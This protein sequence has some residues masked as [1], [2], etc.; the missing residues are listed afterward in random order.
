MCVCGEDEGQNLAARTWRYLSCWLENWQKISWTRLW[1]IISQSADYF[2]STLSIACLCSELFSTAGQSSPR[3]VV[4]YVLCYL[5]RHRHPFVRGRQYV[6]YCCC[7][8]IWWPPSCLQAQN[9]SRSSIAASPESA[10]LLQ[11]SQWSQSAQPVSS[12]HPLTS[13]PGPNDR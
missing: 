5:F 13:L 4:L 7:V 10:N 6:Y 12:P 9:S 3:Q 8:P 11:V 1:W 2:S